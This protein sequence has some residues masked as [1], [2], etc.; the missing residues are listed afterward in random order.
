MN[1]FQEEVLKE[2][3]MKSLKII[4]AACY[5]YIEFLVKENKQKQQQQILMNHKKKNI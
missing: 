1:Y 5:N 3:V 4:E 2:R